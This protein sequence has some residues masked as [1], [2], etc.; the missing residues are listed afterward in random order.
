MN[1]TRRAGVRL[2]VIDPDDLG[3]NGAET[4]V[5]DPHC[6]PGALAA[7]RVLER[8]TL[9]LWAEGPGWRCLYPLVCTPTDG[10]WVARTPEYGGPWI[11][12]PRD[13]AGDA[14]RALREAL[15]AH[16]PAL[17]IVSEVFVLSVWLPH[18]PAVA[19]AWS[20]R[21]PREVVVVT[22]PA[23]GPDPAT[24]GSQRRRD[25]RRAGPAAVAV[26]PL[27]A[28]GAARF[29]ARYRA[30]SAR[31]G[32]EPRWQL[33]SE[34]FAALV[35]AGADAHLAWW[36]CEPGGAAAVLLTHGPR[37]SYAWV[38]RWG[39][40][41]GATTAMLAGALRAAARHGPAEVL[42]GG[43]RTDDPDDGL[44]SFKR[45]WGG[46]TVPL[47]VGAR[48]YDPAGHDAAVRAGQARPLPGWAVSA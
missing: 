4:L 22:V 17:G 15:D 13:R 8:R 10:G 46:R 11:D 30:W 25:L 24:W 34:F 1:V 47:P 19:A 12:T 29:A 42:L 16:L 28:A 31:L 20:T 7:H 35:E 26:A 39:E 18:R 27:D 41:P 36:E 43:G 21:S 40:V 14:A 32:V 37:W 9:H 5:L 44:F 2:E 38:A 48:V 3:R 45:T 23:G 6:R 33:G